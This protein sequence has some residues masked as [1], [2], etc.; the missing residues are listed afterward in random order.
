MQPKAPLPQ[1]ILSDINRFNSLVVTKGLLPVK[2]SPFYLQKVAEEVA[3]LGKADGPLSRCAI[4]PTKRIQLRAPGEV[5]D[6]VN[7]REQM[8]DTAPHTIVQ[9]YRNRLLFLP[10]DV[11]AGHCQYCFRTNVLTEQ[12]QTKLPQL[13]EKIDQLIK[14]LEE[15]PEVEEVILSG[16]DPL[17]LPPKALCS[18]LRRIKA[19][20]IE[21]IRVHTRTLVYAPQVFDDERCEALAEAKVRVVHHMVHPYEICD[22]VRAKI[23]KLNESGIRSYNQFPVLRKVNDHVEVLTRLLRELDELGI[24]NLSMFIPDPIDYSATFRI[25]LERLFKLI[26]KL[27]WT[28]SSWLNST[29][30]VMDTQ[31]GK[32]RR[33]DLKHRDKE[34]GIATFEREGITI[35]YPD[36]PEE[37]DDPG[38]RNTLLWKN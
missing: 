5:A 26:D 7:E 14:Y 20:K 32:V 30:L 12:H 22:T 9:K 29:R 17:M 18:L 4:P 19:A 34:R 10:T 16:G 25:P 33:E 28:T 24:R 8:P 35:D 31:F 23:Q 38:D 1:N 37:L 21:N 27:N 6:F 11:C 2:I 36:F 15:H 3:T 13:E